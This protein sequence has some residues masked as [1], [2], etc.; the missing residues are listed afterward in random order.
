MT[1]ITSQELSSVAANGGDW[2]EEL[3]D[4]K[5]DE[6]HPQFY[7]GR[8]APT[9]PCMSEEGATQGHVSNWVVFGALT[10]RMITH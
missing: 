5:D 2:A 1:D 7:E 8:C 6:A 10:L 4:I 9:P 3:A